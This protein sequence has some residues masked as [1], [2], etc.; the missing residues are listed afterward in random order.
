[1]RDEASSR[2]LARS[3]AQAMRKR[4][5]P[6]E[7]KLWVALRSLRAEGLHFRRQAPF[8]GY[9]LD[10]VC[11]SRRLVVEVDGAQHT[12]AAQAAHDEVRDR[13]LERE[14][15]RTLRVTGSDVLNRL[16]SV[17]DGILAVLETRPTP[18]SLRSRVPPPHKG[19]G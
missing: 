16:A 15:F 3:R 2:A 19:E 1:M 12:Q 6:P 10:F 14:G 9:I 17:M 7:A 4:L 18:H 5:S 13:V 11:F 8:R